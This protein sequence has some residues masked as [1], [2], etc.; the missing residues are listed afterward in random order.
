[1]ALMIG[2]Y[3]PYMTPEYIYNEMTWAEIGAAVDYVYR[4][5]TTERHYKGKKKLDDWI[6]AGR[7]EVDAEL[8]KFIGKM[9]SERGG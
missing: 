8:R 3:W 2:R 9:R 7:D 6:C 1:M 5:E 4:F